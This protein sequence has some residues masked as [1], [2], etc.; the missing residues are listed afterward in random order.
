MVTYFFFVVLHT[1]FFPLSSLAEIAEDVFEVIP[2]SDSSFPHVQCGCCF[3]R[4]KLIIDLY[5]IWN[6][7]GRSCIH[8]ASSHKV[9]RLLHISDSCSSPCIPSSSLS[10]SVLELDLSFYNPDDDLWDSFSSDVPLGACKFSVAFWMLCDFPSPS[11][12]S[13]SGTNTASSSSFMKESHFCNFG[14][15]NFINFFKA[16]IRLPKPSILYLYVPEDS[17]AATFFPFRLPI[18]CAKWPTSF[19]SLCWSLMD[20]TLY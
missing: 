18:F 11:S 17:T 13:S 14:S 7:K 12:L 1:F 20:T 8:S 2:F 4:C 5:I 9:L 10:L 3:F 15:Q 6:L 16:S 19:Q